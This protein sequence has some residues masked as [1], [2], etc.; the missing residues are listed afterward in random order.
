MKDKL[1]QYVKWVKG[2]NVDAL[3]PRPDGSESGSDYYTSN[4]ANI[5]IKQLKTMIAALLAI[6]FIVGG[7]VL[8]IRNKSVVRNTVKEQDTV[9]KVELADKN[10]DPEKHWRNYFEER[11]DNYAK[12]IERRLDELSKEQRLVLKKANELIERELAEN[13][14]KLSM[15]QQEL[16][17][18]SL[19]LKRVAKNKKNTVHV[20]QYQNVELGVQDFDQDVAYDIPKSAK[21]YIPEGI[22]FTG[23][24]LGGIS[25]STGLNTP[26]ENATPVVI[27]LMD[28]FDA[29]R[30]RTSNISSLN[31]LKL[32]NCRIIGSSYGDLSSERAIIRLEKM[33]CE[34]D[35]FYIT[36]KIA[37]QIF[38]PDG[39]NGI[40]GTVISTATKHIKNAAIGGLISGVTSASKGQDGG[41]M[42]IA[43]ITTTPKKGA[44]H[45]LREGAMQGVSN[46][47]EKI[48]DYYLRQAEAMSPT[49]TVP[50]GVRVN[51]RI[52]KGFFVGEVSTHRKIRKDRLSNKHAV[53]SE[54][55]NRSEYME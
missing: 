8:F 52:T 4:N 24:L 10:L 25:V 32:G 33:I 51:T 31:K 2:K 29:K 16:A 14:E 15:A 17:S 11:Q 26:D 22:Y 41:V 46:A 28:R 53:K 18:A 7:I 1:S 35:G 42:N 6:G 12:S 20:P 54:Q 3:K 13:K 48:A 44:R 45:L 55:N 27:Q 34:E 39:L 38:G 36:S 23:H 43:G 19:D 5:R 9:L 21:N 50:S 30:N 40:K 47:G 37:G 49:L